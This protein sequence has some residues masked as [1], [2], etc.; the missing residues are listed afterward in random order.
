MLQQ[1]ALDATDARCILVVEK[2]AIFQSLVHARIFDV[3]PMVLMT[4]KACVF[5]VIEKDVPI[6]NT[7][8]I[9]IIVVTIVIIKHNLVV[10]GFPRPCQP[11]VFAHA[12]HQQPGAPRLC[13]CRLEPRRG[14]HCAHLQVWLCTH[15]LRGVHVV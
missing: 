10:V 6:E 15:G 5:I 11:R 12:A 13:T 4:A 1:L 2:D 9:I 7:T 3:L 14:V 8:I